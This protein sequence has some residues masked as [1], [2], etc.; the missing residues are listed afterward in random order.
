LIIWSLGE[1][2]A[3]ATETAQTAVRL[4]AEQA[5]YRKVAVDWFQQ[6]VTR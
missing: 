1:V 6:V 4:V 3:V 5:Q 2:R